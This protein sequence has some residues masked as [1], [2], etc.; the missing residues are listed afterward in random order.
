MPFSLHTFPNKM[1]VFSD[2]GKYYQ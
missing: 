1:H 2:D